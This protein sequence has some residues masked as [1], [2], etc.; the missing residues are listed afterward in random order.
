MNNLYLIADACFSLLWRMFK[1]DANLFSS[2]WFN[3][4]AQKHCVIVGNEII[5][6][7]SES[8]MVSSA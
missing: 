2:E 3:I 8:I 7:I 5:I 1:Q 4:L 6:N